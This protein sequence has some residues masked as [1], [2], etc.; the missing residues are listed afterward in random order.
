[1]GFT[2]HRSL[3]RERAVDCPE[4][5]ES[6]IVDELLLQIEIAESDEARDRYQEEL[7]ELVASDENAAHTYEAHLLLE[8]ELRAL[9]DDPGFMERRRISPIRRFFSRLRARFWPGPSG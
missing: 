5:R 7:D 9:F 6:V 1:M 3:K 8:R 2:L 4:D